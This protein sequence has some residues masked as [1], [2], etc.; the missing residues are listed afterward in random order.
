MYDAEIT[1]AD[2]KI[3]V[4]ITS[5]TSNI[6]FSRTFHN[7]CDAER[8]I[9]GLVRTGLTKRARKHLREQAVAPSELP[10]LWPI[11]VRDKRTIKRAVLPTRLE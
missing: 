11:V 1:N 10:A 3:M 7:I 5:S 8:W 4:T 2:G 6:H 9:I